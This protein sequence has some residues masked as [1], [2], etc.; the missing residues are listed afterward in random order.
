M[1]GRVAK[2]L[3]REQTEKPEPQINPHFGSSRRVSRRRL[4]DR[5]YTRSKGEK[6]NHIVQDYRE[7]HI[8]VKGTNHE[9]MLLRKGYRDAIRIA[10]E[11][12][13]VADG[14]AH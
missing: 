14:A 9:R 7:Q 5:S 6:A 13:K 4:I 10:M 3:R 11:K 2:R 12:N 8:T 1:N